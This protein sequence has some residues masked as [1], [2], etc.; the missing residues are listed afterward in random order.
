MARLQVGP[1]PSR[2]I[3]SRKWDKPMEPPYP[4]LLAE[5][6]GRGKGERGR[7][8]EIRYALLDS[9]RYPA[10]YLP[11]QLFLSS[12]RRRRRAFPCISFAFP[13]DFVAKIMR[14]IRSRRA[15]RAECCGRAR[16][17]VPFPVATKLW[18]EARSAANARCIFI[19]VHSLCVRVCARAL[20][21]HH[22]FFN[23]LL[24]TFLTS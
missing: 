3:G 20:A 17:T 1:A 16:S 15:V 18:H 5:A 9:R 14:L 21:W 22:F 7:T 6:A 13:D 2:E 12:H 4:G 19:A 11:Y 23:L 10:M 24:P 8:V